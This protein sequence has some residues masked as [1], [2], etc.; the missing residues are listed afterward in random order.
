MRHAV[1]KAALEKL[2]AVPVRGRGAGER[3]GK[4]ALDLI[5]GSSLVPYD[6]FSSAGEDSILLSSTFD[7]TAKLA[8]F[9]IVSRLFIWVHWRQAV[10]G[11]RLRLTDQDVAEALGVD[12]RTIQ[13]HK[14]LLVERGYL[15]VEPADEKFSL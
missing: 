7:W 10:A 13:N 11:S 4:L 9:G 3:F 2:F 8:E 6:G 12:R 1:P 14:Q 15:R 5:T